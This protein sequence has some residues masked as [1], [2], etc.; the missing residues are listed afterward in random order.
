MDIYDV[1]TKLIGPIN[2]VGD[3]GVDE[4]R[5]ENL[6]ATTDLV[7]DLLR[8]IDAV[9]AANKDRYEASRKLAGRYASDFFDRIGIKE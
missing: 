5:F 7:N 8:D 9:A 2:P 1:V 4:Q 6:K 3:T